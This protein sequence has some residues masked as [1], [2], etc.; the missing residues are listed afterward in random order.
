MQ[1]TTEDYFDVSAVTCDSPADE[2]ALDIVTRGLALLS[3]DERETVMEHLVAGLT[4]REIAELRGRP[5][6][7]V[8]TWYRRGIEKLRRNLRQHDE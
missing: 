3:D 2:L 6:G 1:P 5:I 8:G 7:T 4:F